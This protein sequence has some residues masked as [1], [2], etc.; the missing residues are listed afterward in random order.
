MKKRFIA[1]ALLLA[2]L[3]SLVACLPEDKGDPDEDTPGEDDT[4]VD[5]VYDVINGLSA[6]S[7]TKVKLDISTVTGEIELKASYSLTQSSVTY[8][9]EKLNMLP[10]DGDMTNASPDY[11]KTVTGT[12]VVENGKVTQLDGEA[13]TLPTYDELKGAFN[14]NK[15]NFSN[16]TVESGKLSASVVSPSTFLGTQ[17]SVTDMKITIEY[18]SS[19]L[20]SVTLTY[21]TASSSVNTVYTF[22]K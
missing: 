15:S 6:Q 19:S 5:A 10:T 9:V 11:K 21:K 13:V 20:E 14:F 17:V 12:A 4:N 7:Y 22:E 18:N 16:V 1:F 8:S 2:L 3:M